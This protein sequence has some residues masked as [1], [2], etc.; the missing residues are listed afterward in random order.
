VSK[1]ANVATPDLV[2]GVF[3]G[4]HREIVMLTFSVI[5]EVV[6]M[7][8]RFRVLEALFEDCERDCRKDCEKRSGKDHVIFR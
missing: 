7:V 2:E 3:A 4:R 6:A 8:T 5:H 1:P